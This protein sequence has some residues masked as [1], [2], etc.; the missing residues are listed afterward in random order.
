MAEL[1]SQEAHRNQH[2]AVCVCSNA[3]VE[4][5]QQDADPKGTINNSSATF[6]Q[7]AQVELRLNAFVALP[8]TVCK[9]DYAKAAG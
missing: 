4:Q 8:G 7:Q 6:L 9:Q 2:L 3:A 1:H 5:Q